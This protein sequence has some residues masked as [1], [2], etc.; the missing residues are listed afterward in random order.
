[1]PTRRS[2]APYAAATAGAAGRSGR[3][4][5]LSQRGGL[6]V[7]VSSAAGR[8]SGL[9]IV[10]AS[11]R[12]TADLGR[13]HRRLVFRRPGRGLDDEIGGL[14]G[15][16]LVHLQQRAIAVIEQQL[17]LVDDD[18]RLFLGQLGERGRF[19]SEIVIRSSARFL[20]SALRRWKHRCLP[21][22]H[23]AFLREVFV[24]PL[25]RVEPVEAGFELRRLRPPARPA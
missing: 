6:L 24:G 10:S 5:Q 15:Q 18:A 21:R 20:R 14:F 23:G 25:Q 2:T 13:Q 22:W 8:S 12:A 9:R 17:I 1:M 3:R 11:S 16:R 4:R 19:L 7:N